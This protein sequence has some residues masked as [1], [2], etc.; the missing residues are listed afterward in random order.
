[1]PCPPSKVS[2]FVSLW[3]GYPTPM[4]RTDW[5]RTATELGKRLVVTFGSRGILRIDGRAG[6]ERR[7]V[8]D[9]VP[10]AGTTVGCG[11]AFIE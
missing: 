7:I 9:P 2:A 4:D 5:W 3:G 8:V 11:D 1:M 10:V 6:L